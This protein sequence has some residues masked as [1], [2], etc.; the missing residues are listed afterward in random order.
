LGVCLSKLFDADG[1]F[2]L[3]CK[4]MYSARVVRIVLE[5]RTFHLLETKVI[6]IPILKELPS[7][8]KIVMKYSKTPDYWLEIISFLENTHTFLIKSFV[9]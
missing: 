3:I 2:I 4:F 7:N 9:F 6:S 5:Y 1:R 8:L